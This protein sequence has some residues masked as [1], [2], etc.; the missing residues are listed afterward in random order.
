MNILIS[1]ETGGEDV[2]RQ[3]VSPDAGTSDA[4]SR[5]RGELVKLLQSA[6]EL[7]RH[8]RKRPSK[9][10]FAKFGPGQLP[11]QLRHDAAARFVSQR[12]AARLSAPIIENRYSMDLVDVTRSINHP[13]LFPILTRH[14]SAEN[15]QIL[16]DEIHQPHRKR[17]RRMVERML[18][19]SSYVVHLSIRSFESIAPTR[20]GTKKATKRSSAKKSKAK[21]KHRRA[22]VGLLYDVSSVDEVD[23]SADLYEEMY[24]EAEMLKVRRNYPR[25]G[26]VDSLTKALRSEF[27]GQYYIGIEILVNQAWSLRKGSLR[28]EAIDRMCGS[29]QAV[30]QCSQSEAA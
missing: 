26:T 27:D 11:N 8:K 3:L 14:W 16:I 23:F 10:K 15:R 24:F 29:I 2:P 7:S 4:S 6:H 17:V 28:N 5:H 9:K 22:D 12:M 21:Q 25:R 19:L 13:Q 1:C 18:G 20:S 30:L